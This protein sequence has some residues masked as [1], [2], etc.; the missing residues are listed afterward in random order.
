M[1]NLHSLILLFRYLHYIY[2]ML[3]MLRSCYKTLSH[4]SDLL[5]CLSCICMLCKMSPYLQ[6]YFCILKSLFFCIHL[7]KHRSHQ[8]QQNNL[9]NLVQH[10]LEWWW[11]GLWKRKFNVDKVI[12]TF[13][14]LNCN[15]I[16][17]NLH[18]LVQISGDEIKKPSE[19][20]KQYELSR[21]IL[22]LATQAKKI[23][24]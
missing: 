16:V 2:I 6:P 12:T 13:V 14:V 21:Q 17:I 24:C 9:H 19:Q 23:R 1:Y 20:D 22:Q 15:N 4:Q 7:H 18:I 8:H 5:N 11:D 10:N 3:K